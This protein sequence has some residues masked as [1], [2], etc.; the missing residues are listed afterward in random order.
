MVARTR[1]ELTIESVRFHL[2]AQFLVE[3]TVCAVSGRSVTKANI[4]TTQSTDV[5]LGS[6]SGAYSR[7]TRLWVIIVRTKEYL[8]RSR[9]GHDRPFCC[10]LWLNEYKGFAAFWTL[11]LR[12]AV[13]GKCRRGTPCRRLLLSIIFKILTFSH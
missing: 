1:N 6:I 9:G 10:T 4:A 2:I 3:Y 8:R 5:A 13:V 7:K 11:V 12:L